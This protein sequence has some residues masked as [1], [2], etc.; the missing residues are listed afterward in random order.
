MVWI[1]LKD[2]TFIPEMLWYSVHVIQND[3]KYFGTV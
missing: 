1:S 3:S 2:M